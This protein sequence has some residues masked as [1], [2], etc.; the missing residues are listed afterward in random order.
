MAS[1]FVEIAEAAH[2]ESQARMR[3]VRLKREAAVA[4]ARVAFNADVVVLRKKIL[5]LLAEAAQACSAVG[6]PPQIKDNFKVEIGHLG[7]PAAQVH[8]WCAGPARAPA[9]G[10][11]M[12]TPSS[13]RV[14]FR[15]YRG[16]LTMGGDC[17]D[18]AVTIEGDAR[19]H[20]E[21]AV[22]KVLKGYFL[23]RERAEGGA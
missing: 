4:A 3:A 8:F 9:S 1:R 7:A 19:P 18:R 12:V 15:C 20:I 6:A 11:A 2:E 17:F 22:D 14:E 5:P 10:T 13:E 21:V 23:D 16:M